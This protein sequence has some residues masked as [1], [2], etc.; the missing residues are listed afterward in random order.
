MPFPI[1]C[2]A[3]GATFN[4]PD[5]IY[6][7]RVAG[8]VVNIRCKQ[9]KADILVDGTAGE[10]SAQGA[11][12]RPPA[13]GQSPQPAPQTPVAP[14]AQQ[15]RSESS[16]AVTNLG[17]EPASGSPPADESTLPSRLG[18]EAAVG[19]IADESI[20]PA[21]LTHG[22]PPA[23]SQ[24]DS[25]H[26]S[27]SLAQTDSA[28]MA[29]SAT[30]PQHTEPH[31]S[32]TS[33]NEAR[34]EHA[35]PRA[36]PPTQDGSE[37]SAPLAAPADLWAVS[38]GDDDD[39][40]LTEAQ[41]A[42]EA[43]RGNLHRD[44]L[45]WR[46]GMDGWLPIHRV[47]E[48]ARLLPGEASSDRVNEAATQTKASPAMPPPLARTTLGVGPVSI[49]QAVATPAPDAA[50]ADDPV[51]TPVLSGPHSPGGSAALAAAAPAEAAPA[52][53]APLLAPPPVFAPVVEP[54]APALQQAAFNPFMGGSAPPG[55]A[56]A[57]PSA[58][59]MRP[60]QPV[61]FELE[62]LPPVKRGRPVLW[63]TA[64]VAVVALGVVIGLVTSWSSPQQRPVPSVA[65][66]VP[67]APATDSRGVGTVAGSSREPTRSAG[68]VATSSGRVDLFAPPGSRTRAPTG[69]AKSEPK[70]RSSRKPDLADVF[71]DKLKNKGP[72]R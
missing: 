27:A 11:S 44:M 32:E 47:Q 35:T 71:A 31:P 28:G 1:S 45:V 39:R 54:S 14:A 61:S 41:I 57:G 16:T 65:A 42:E 38:F 3:C 26:G 67:S 8:R 53:A 23:Q 6:R 4:I 72:G 18:A 68:S 58:P 36:A 13:T 63:M 10:L 46:E 62:A 66:S 25:P 33:E 21:P 9:C 43:E 15:V 64:I 49:P 69:A 5:D 37:Q 22:A 30:V 12:P 50:R 24:L 55:P 70:K 51:A 2:A 7:R 17:S 40:E 34:E 29:T 19:Q 59:P 52:P 56:P 60:S 20:R 48:L